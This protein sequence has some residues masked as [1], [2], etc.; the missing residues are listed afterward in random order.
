ML[1]YT[2]I[3]DHVCVCVRILA[4]LYIY[5]HTFLPFYRIPFYIVILLLIFHPETYSCTLATHPLY[6][7]LVKPSAPDL[8]T[9][10]FRKVARGPLKESKKDPACFTG[11][12]TYSKFGRKAL[13]IRN[14]SGSTITCILLG[15]GV[16]I[17]GTFGNVSFCSY[18]VKLIPNPPQGHNLQVL[19]ISVPPILPCWTTTDFVF[20]LKAIRPHNAS[21]F[22]LVAG[23]LPKASALKAQAKAFFLASTSHRSYWPWKWRPSSTEDAS[24]LRELIFRKAIDSKP[25][26]V[27]SATA[28]RVSPL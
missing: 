14:D 2:S 27:S 28:M 22:E 18:L 25:F 7:V 19:L 11:F 1:S 10:G 17:V 15:S 5:A 8:F 21:G 13:S 9:Y 24:S 26:C 3:Q 4:A 6:S 16:N 12:D 20:C 23:Y